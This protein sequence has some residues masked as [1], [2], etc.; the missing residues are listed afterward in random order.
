MKT[1]LLEAV[2]ILICSGVL[3]GAYEL[4]LDRRISPRRCRIYLLAVPWLAIL[5]PWMH[6]PL[7]PAPVIEIEPLVFA[8]TVESAPASVA[9]PSFPLAETAVGALWLAGTL[10]MLGAIARQLLTI[11]HL[12][13]RAVLDRSSHPTVART[14]ERIAPFSFCRTIY[15][16]EGTPAEERR[17][18][19]AHETG[20]IAHGHS[21]ER[22]LMECMKALMWWN[23]FVWLAARRLAEAQEYEADR[24]VLAQGCDREL[25]M[26]TIFRQLFGYSP[27]IANGLRNSLTKKRFQMMT[28][29]FSGRY[30]L[31]R[32]AGTALAITGLLC[33]FSLTARAAEIRTAPASADTA[34]GTKPEPLFIVNG[35]EQDSKENASYALEKV[36]ASVKKGT[37]VNLHKLSPEE[38]MKKY[39]EKG[40]NGVVEIRVSTDSETSEA[41][42]V[43]AVAAVRYGK[44]SGSHASETTPP[45][46]EATADPDE[47][48]LTTETMP[49]FQ[50]GS[51]TDFRTWVQQHLRYPDTQAAGRVVVTFVVE[52]DGS[53]SSF[54]VLASPDEALSQEALRLLG[55]V[56][57]GSWTPGLQGGEAVRVRYTLPIEFQTIADETPEPQEK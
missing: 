53:I 25:Y 40:R 24:D 35:E 21:A 9:A 14:R 44:E 42:T 56:P 49:K 30:A 34:A 26:S 4:L 5:I 17:T 13:R 37:S 3:W 16:W 33:T 50:G 39:G 1:L 55:S 20:H 11:G 43:P 18:I 51:L 12:R 22:I 52:R 28:T 7:L 54:K 19:V 29:P 6:I 31:L 27:D 15:L 57:A 41:T 2:K 32:L 47:P 38:A 10:V 46:S 36:L 23:P 48:W 45:T 8:E